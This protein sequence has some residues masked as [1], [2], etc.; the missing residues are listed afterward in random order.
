MA[1]H[2]RL[3]AVLGTDDEGDQLPLG[4]CQPTL[5]IRVDRPAQRVLRQG[6][7]MVYRH[8]PR[9]SLCLGCAERDAEMA[10]RAGPLLIPRGA[11]P[12]GARGSGRRATGRRG[13]RDRGG[14]RRRGI[15]IACKRRAVQR[16]AISCLQK[17]Q[18]A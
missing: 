3:A 12:G 1:E 14:R 8:T 4:V 7:G 2:A 10:R 16:F 11:A 5:L 6:Q 13:G 17:L 15:R 18:F 9:E